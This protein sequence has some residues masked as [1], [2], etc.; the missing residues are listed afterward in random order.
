M[1]RLLILASFATLAACT[2]ISGGENG[3]GGGSVGARISWRCEGGH[4]FSVGFTHNSA[5]VSVNGR[6]YNLLHA[7]S[8]SGARYSNGSV[9]Y[10]E[11]A[12]Q[13][14]LSGVAG[15]PYVNCRRG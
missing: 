9:E 6:T 5:L 7:Q 3:G 13:V 14:Q 10:W 12:G 15:G 8:A 11:H 2:T 4:A 1:K